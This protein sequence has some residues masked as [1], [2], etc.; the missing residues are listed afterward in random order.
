MGATLAM[1]VYTGGIYPLPQTVVAIAFYA[2]SCAVASRS[3]RPILYAIGGG[4]LSFAFS[5]P[6]LLPLMDMLRRFPRLVDST[7]TMS[8]EQIVGVFTAK[9]GHYPG[10]GPWGYHEFGIY[11]GWTPFVLMLVG[12]FFA[13]R[14]RERGLRL[15]G[16]FAL[17]LGFGRF[18]DWSPWG[19]LH[20]YVPVFESQ[21][22][23]SRWLYPMALL[24]S[25]A[26]AAIVERFLA[27]QTR[28]NWL[29]VGVLALGMWVC[30]DVAIE[31][32]H[33][34]VGAFIR[35]L[36]VKE[37]T[38]DF[39]MES[40]VRADLRYDGSDWAPPS[41]GPMM[42]NIGAK[43]CSTFPGLHTYYWAKGGTPGLGAKGRDEPGY[44][45]EVY[46]ASGVGTAGIV[47][48]SPNVVVVAVE[49]VQPGDLVV[50]NQNWDPGWR[51]SGAASGNVDY[52]SAAAAKL[53]RGS[54]EVVF[55]YVPR[56]FWLGCLIFLVTIIG[57]IWVP[58]R[59]LLKKA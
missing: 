8:V 17:V 36:H 39:H 29:E 53:E 51:A 25:V 43:E 5:A 56:F 11:V 4:L 16:A 10:V 42:A 3:W 9:E 28:R 31:A 13:A 20:D 58:R 32:Q 19:F 21:H 44:H 46:T 30:A 37:S 24:L 18:H 40:T 1:M 15:A 59:V 27:R 52:K 38:G 54:G 12:L 35:T 49:G 2:I 47:T 14:A 26:G 7:E 55:R 33:P 6:R 34:L 50:L 48:W 57:L 45:G 41:L 22:V 23:P